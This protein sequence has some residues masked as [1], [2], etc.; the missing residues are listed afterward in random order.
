MAGSNGK[1][2]LPRLVHANLRH[3][4]LYNLE[5][6]IEIS[7]PGGVFCLA[8]ANGLG[9][10]T[11]LIAIN[12]AITGRVP[13]PERD[14]VSLGDYYDRTEDFSRSF[15]DGRISERDRDVAEVE[16]QLQVGGHVIRLVEECL[17]RKGFANC[18]LRRKTAS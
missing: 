4:T 15:F 14:F 11:F 17:N 1:L 18:G 8:G 2:C 3:F 5:P 12:Y 7:F 13:E 16:L 9:K 6:E 10:S